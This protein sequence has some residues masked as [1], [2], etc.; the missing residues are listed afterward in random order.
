MSGKWTRDLVTQPNV[1]GGLSI[2]VW[3]EV[4]NGRLFVACGHSVAAR[5]PLNLR[6]RAP[7]ETSEA[8]ANGHLWAA[9][10]ALYEA[11]EAVTQSTEWSC[12]E[13]GIQSAVLTALA[14]ARGE[15]P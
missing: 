11:L 6:G 5:N 9:A 1:G 2:G 7:I 10:P 3:H 8:V 13:A 14:Q 4:K 15:Q 12:M